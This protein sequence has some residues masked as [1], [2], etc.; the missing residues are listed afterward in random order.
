MAGILKPLFVY[1]ASILM[2]VFSQTAFNEEAVKA[3]TQPDATPRSSVLQDSNKAIQFF[4]EEIEFTTNPH[5]VKQLI[6]K[7]DKSVTIVDVRSAKDFA[8]GH[9]PGAI[10][11]PYEQYNGFHG[12]ETEFK[13]LRKDGYNYIYCYELLC[14]LAKNAAIKFASLGYPVKEVVGGFDAW[15]QKGNAIEK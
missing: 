10:N 13:G 8:A 4:K 15:K 9:I 1:G 7:K 3:A 5:D 12:N 6:D 2:L 11:I 14:N